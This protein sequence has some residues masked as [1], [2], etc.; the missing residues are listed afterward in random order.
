MEFY[1]SSSFAS[2]IV[3][4]RGHTKVVQQSPAAKSN[5]ENDCKVLIAYF[6]KT[7]KLEKSLAS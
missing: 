7:L 3:D 2:M 5:Y 4:K 1:V 6:K